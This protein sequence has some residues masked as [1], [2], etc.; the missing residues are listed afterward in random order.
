MRQSSS[1]F[2]CNVNSKHTN[3][4]SKHVP[5]GE[6][7]N[8]LVTIQ[9]SH[10]ANTA[11]TLKLAHVKQVL[12][13][14]LFRFLRNK[15]FPIFPCKVAQNALVGREKCM[16]QMRRSVLA[17][18][19]CR[20]LGC[21][22]WAWEKIAEFYSMALRHKW[23]NVSLCRLTRMWVAEMSYHV[24]RSSYVPHAC[25]KKQQIHGVG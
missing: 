5:S 3:V 19:A 2:W 1:P 25:E 4:H 7:G 13:L 14:C 23:Y 18:C 21:A 6:E 20:I 17:A 12:L 16:R 22:N 8:V 15:K 9:F 11:K 24:G 10:I